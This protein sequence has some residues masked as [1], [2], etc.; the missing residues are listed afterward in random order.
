VLCPDSSQVDRKIF[1]LDRSDFAATEALLANF[2][3]PASS[4]FF[5]PTLTFWLDF[6]LSCSGCERGT[7]AKRYSRQPARSTT[8]NVI[9]GGARSLIPVFASGGATGSAV[10]SSDKKYP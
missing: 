8:A 10:T 3:P 6:S 2:D 1:A 4:R 7:T 9:A 5:W